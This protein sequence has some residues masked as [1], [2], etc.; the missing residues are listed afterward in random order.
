[1]KINPDFVGERLLLIGHGSALMGSSGVGHSFR[2]DA[3]RGCSLVFNK[4]LFYR[5]FIVGWVHRASY[6]ATE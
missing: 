3:V 2:Q 6:L 5:H 4:S 1:M